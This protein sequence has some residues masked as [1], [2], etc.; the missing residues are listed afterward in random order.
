MYAVCKSILAGIFLV[1]VH[2][3]SVSWYSKGGHAKAVNTNIFKS[4]HSQTLTL[5]L[6]SAFSH[7]FH[8]FLT[9]TFS[10]SRCFLLSKF[11]FLLIYSSFFSFLCDT[12]IFAI[13]LF[14][15]SIVKNCGHGRNSFPLINHCN[16]I[17]FRGFASDLV[18]CP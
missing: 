13:R 5:F 2:G 11:Y 9:F 14:I 18:A 17:L 4:I 12:S 7:Q 8:D 15:C 16:Y 10:H 3:F 1:G 6:S